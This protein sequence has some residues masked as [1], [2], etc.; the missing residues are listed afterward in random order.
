MTELSTAPKRPG[1]VLGSLIAVAAVANLGLAVANV[2]L[3]SIGK[4]F[5]ASQT[6]LN[7]V[8]VGYSLGLAASV[9]YFGAVGDRYGRKL[10]LLVGMVVTITADCLAAWA[11]T[12]EVL[13]GA[14]VLGGL[15]AG[16]AYPTTLALITALWSGPARTKSIALWAATGG[17]ISALGPL[18]A[19]VLLDHFWWGSVFLITLPLAVIALLMALKLVP[20]HVKETTEPVDHLGGTLSVLAVGQLILGI[21]IG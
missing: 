17:A 20:S 12:I 19:G 7:L 5:D 14:R 21:K 16:M 4:E 11:P 6:E 10:L 1:L 8:A 3:P 13:F 2:A 9:L 15:A 18:T